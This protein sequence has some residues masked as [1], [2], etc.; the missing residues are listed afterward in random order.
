MPLKFKETD[1]KQC[2]TCKSTKVYDHP[3][4]RYVWSCMY[5]HWF[6]IRLQNG[7]LYEEN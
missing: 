2:P 6:L 3:E 7:D 5:G 1:K 4:M